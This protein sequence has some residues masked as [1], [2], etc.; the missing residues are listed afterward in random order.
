MFF[1]ADYHH[2]YLQ[3]P[4]TAS[5]VAMLLL[6]VMLV[7]WV[8]TPCELVGPDGVTTHKTNIGDHIMLFD[9][10]ETSMKRQRTNSLCLHCYTNTAKV[11]EG[12]DR[13]WVR[14]SGLTS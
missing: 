10:F 8:L 11:Y 6:I 13:P 14:L 9:R 12:Q 5:P 7:F 2:I 4:L 3:T 1:M